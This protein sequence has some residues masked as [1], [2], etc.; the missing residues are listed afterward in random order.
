MSTPSPMAHQL[1][2]ERTRDLTARGAN[3]GSTLTN[4][5]QEQSLFLKNRY[6]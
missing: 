5:L 1:I 3:L 6:A 4:L 2:I